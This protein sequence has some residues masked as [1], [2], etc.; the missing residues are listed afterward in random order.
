MGQYYD[1]T[2]LLSLRDINGN[3]PE[4]YI[5]TTN[6]TGGKTT[7][8]NRYVVKKFLEGKGKFAVLYRF[9]KQLK[10]CNEKFFKDVGELFFPEYDM[11]AESRGDGDYY[12]LFLYKKGEDAS[13]KPG[14]S[15]GYALALNS[16]DQI[17]QQSH[18]LNDID[19]MIFDEFQSETNHYCTDEISK[20]ISVHTSV[21]RGHGKQSRYVPVYML[22]NHVS[23]LNPYFIEFDISTRLQEET[24]FLRGEGFVLENGFVDSA[25]EAMKQSAFNRAFRRNKQIAYLQQK[26]YLN[27]NKAFVER[28]SGVGRYI[29]TIKYKDNEYGIRA[30]DE[31]G[32]IYCDNRPDMTF[33]LKLSITTDDHNINYVMLRAYADFIQ[34]LR[35]YFDHGCFRFKDLKCKEAILKALTY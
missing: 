17:K 32:I 27:D 26:T 23:L 21:A 20:F 25:S 8:F 2:K 1:G 11:R 9:A 10:D 24:K 14:K 28:V 31:Q 33:P 16:A 29:A 13:K 30:F 12:E 7:F 34:K 35:Y 15:C 18:Q 4:I 6:R 22:S 19:R 3:L 5:C